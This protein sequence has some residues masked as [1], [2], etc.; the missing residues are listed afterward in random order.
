MQ[1]LLSGE[2][3]IRHGVSVIPAK[4]AVIPAKAAVIPAK[5]GI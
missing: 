2:W 1:K 4:A 3:S 5:A